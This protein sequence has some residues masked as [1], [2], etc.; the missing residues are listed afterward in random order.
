[1]LN[2]GAASGSRMNI[3]ILKGL[4]VKVRI[5]R[6]YYEGGLLKDIG[7]AA[8]YRRLALGLCRRLGAG[9]LV[10]GKGRRGYFEQ[11]Q[12]F[13]LAEED[14]RCGVYDSLSSS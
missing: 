1:M 7:L 8:C 14:Q 13:P 10:F 11:V 9:L 3:G 4:L 2:D 6:E 5:D 12:G